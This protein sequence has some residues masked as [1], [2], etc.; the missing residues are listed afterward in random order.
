M[1]PVEVLQPLLQCRQLTFSYSEDRQP[2]ILTLDENV[3]PLTSTYGS[4]WSPTEPM[5]AFSSWNCPLVFGNHDPSHPHFLIPLETLLS[6]VNTLHPPSPLIHGPHPV[7][8]YNRFPRNERRV[9]CC[10]LQSRPSNQAQHRTDHESTSE[11]RRTPACSILVF[12]PL[13]AQAGGTPALSAHSWLNKQVSYL[14]SF[15]TDLQDTFPFI[16]TLNVFK[17]KCTN[18]TFILHFILLHL[19]Y[20]TNLFFIHGY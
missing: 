16:Q 17:L 1:F 9:G 10:P 7:T 20:H 2:P 13:S 8:S 15:H 11:D 6:G 4:T 5:L 3:F 18:L 14:K 12:V 19:N